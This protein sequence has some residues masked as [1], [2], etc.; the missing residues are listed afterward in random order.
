MSVTN[1]L[2][3]VFEKLKPNAA[4]ASLV[5]S[6]LSVYLCLALL[7][8]GL[9][10]ASLAQLQQLFGYGNQTPIVP[11]SILQAL[12]SLTSG[13]NKNLLV[14]ISNSVYT[15]KSSPLKQSWVDILRTRYQA[16]AEAVD[17]G[18]NQTLALINGRITQAT[19][20]VLKNTIQK[21]NADT[22]SVLVNTIYF[23][24]SW[25]R[26]F[27]PKETKP[28]TFT[29]SDGKQIQVPFMHASNCQWALKSGATA[30]YLALPYV[31]GNIKFVVELFHS[32]KL[33]KSSS[34]DILA[35][36]KQTD[37]EKVNIAIPKFK[38]ETRLDLI[39]TLQSLGIQGIFSAGPDFQKISDS[40]VSVTQVIHQA[41]VQV[42][43]VGTEAAAATVVVMSRCLPEQFKA[44]SP[45][46][47]HI[48]DAASQIILFS[49]AVDSPQF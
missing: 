15:S 13:Q 39:P 20:G 12:T 11:A 6:P 31:G 2:V 48:V 33:D 18:D 3:N 9:T 26:S 29:K 23:K 40:P 36:A 27:D 45:F 28:A 16:H 10:G 19:H 7:G 41:F 5:S 4:G 30:E 14:A 37:T 44:N 47:F 17:F 1:S 35:V 43:E 25:V 38:C 24:G 22:V 34:Q 21:L 49:G 42:D 32:K 46:S 8:E